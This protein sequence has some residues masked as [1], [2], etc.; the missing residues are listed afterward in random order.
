MVSLNITKGICI[1]GSVRKHY[2]QLQEGMERIEDYI[3]RISENLVEK[4]KR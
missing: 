2:L 1:A 4:E 3:L